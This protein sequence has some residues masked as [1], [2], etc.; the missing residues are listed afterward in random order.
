MKNIFLIIIAAVLG[1]VAMDA[2]QLTPA[3]TK[4]KKEIF[5]ALKKY[6]T[7]ITDDGEES[8]SFKYD[9]TTFQASVH[10]L[11][12][13][14]LYLTLFVGFGLPEEYNSEISNIAAF[15]AASGKPVCSF[16]SDGALAFSCEMY[17]KDAKPFIAV[18]P[19]MLIALVSS[20]GEF[21]K[22]YEK[23]AKEY[24]PLSTVAGAIA[25]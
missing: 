24:V 22:E 19:E 9:G 17:A 12:P 8:I 7:N 18:L 14:T 21:Q 15:N 3:Q 10:T 4:A 25:F 2:A 23:A 13:Q 20:V 6:G 5:N 16:S 1:C 11:N